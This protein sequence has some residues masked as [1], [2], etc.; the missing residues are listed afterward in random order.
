[1]WVEAEATMTSHPTPPRGTTRRKR[2]FVCV[3]CSK[4]M[5]SGKELPRGWRV[6]GLA[7]NIRVYW[8]E[9]CK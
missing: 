3:A 5:M 2:R 1:V 6:C 9:R 4:V 8:C 7:H